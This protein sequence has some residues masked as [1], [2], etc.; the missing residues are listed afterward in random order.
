MSLRDLV[1]ADCTGANSLMRLGNQIRRDAAFKDEGL[2]APGTSASFHNRSQQFGSDQL[3]NEFL[4]QIA[5]PQTFRMDSLLQ[6]MRE[7][8][9]QAFHNRIVR[10][11]PVIE[12]VNS[13]IDW[14][15]EFSTECGPHRPVMDQN[16][17]VEDKGFHDIWNQS[18]QPPPFDMAES[19]DSKPWTR[20]FFDVNESLQQMVSLVAV[21][22]DSFQNLMKRLQFKK[23]HD[24]M[25]AVPA[26]PLATADDSDQFKYSEFMKFM[27]NVGDGEIGLDNG[28]IGGTSEDWVKDFNTS[29]KTEGKRCELLTIEFLSTQVNF[30]Q[31][32]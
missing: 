22:V 29:K 25:Q 20:E 5:P 28:A 9:A 2:S 8:D 26:V 14:A 7:I 19:F 32:N 16:V 10:A 6:E 21:L 18:V 23:V 12:E 15:N 13:G 11:P 27:Q 17:T 1:E 24:P 30:F 31:L 4:G 3:V